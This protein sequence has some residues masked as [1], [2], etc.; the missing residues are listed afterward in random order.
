LKKSIVWIATLLIFL[1]VSACSSSSGGDSATGEPAKGNDSSGSNVTLRYGIW[2]QE[3]QPA[4][5]QIVDAFKKTHPNID[6]KIEVTP[7]DQYWTKLE[8]AATGGSLPDLFWINAANFTKYASNG[9]LMDLSDKIKGDN[10]EMSN[11]PQSLVDLYTLNGSHFGIPKDFDTIGL[12][13][14]K[15]LFDK[16]SIPYPDD[17]W[18]WAKIHEVAKKLTNPDQGVWGIA[19][20]VASQEGYYNTIF[21]N[22]GYVISDDKKTSGFDK[23]EA[24]EALKFWTDF[25]AEKSS[26]TLR[27]MTDTLPETLFESGKVA[28]LYAGSWNQVIF[29][30]NEYTKDKVDVAVMPKGKERSTVIHGL[31]YV[32]DSKTKHPKEAW[33]FEKFLGSKEAA[34]I[35]A[36]TGTVIPAFNGTQDPWVKSNPKFNLQIFVDETKY[37]K[38]YPVSV[39]TKKWQQSETDNF[40]KAWAEQISIDDAAKQV[41]KEMNTILEAEKK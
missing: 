40:N 22:G 32:I 33:E 35:Q 9:I 30:Q 34:L 25:I 24:I 10:I 28:M 38:P 18:D 37:S 14:N 41:A 1:L 21:Q 2:A 15:E 3:Q 13:Y 20:Q 11:Y 39:E 26:P 29:S 19:S 6:V 7:W 17:S 4:M 16:A 5:Q 27:Q 23:P 8:A 12:W 36:E 31:S